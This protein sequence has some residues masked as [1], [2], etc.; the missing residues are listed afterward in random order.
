MVCHD[1]AAV[2]RG[3]GS[4]AAFVSPGA[5]ELVSSP[6][7][8]CRRMLAAANPRRTRRYSF[9]WMD[10]RSRQA[11]GHMAGSVDLDGMREWLV[12][13][14]AALTGC[15]DGAGRCVVRGRAGERGRP[16]VPELHWNPGSRTQSA[17]RH[18]GSG[19]IPVGMQQCDGMLKPWAKRQRSQPR[20]DLPIVDCYVFALRHQAD[21]PFRGSP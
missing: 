20:R 18:F 16:R 14:P 15:D 10:R 1:G 8:R 4:A 7:G 2:F 17:T 19:I 5:S 21:H 6:P 9:S 3:A 13:R 12:S 11:L